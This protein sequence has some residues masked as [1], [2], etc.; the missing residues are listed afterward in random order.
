MR[1]VRIGKRVIGEGQ[2]CF[3]IAEAGVN[4]NGDLRLVKRLVKAAAMA[5]ADAVKFQTFSADS[6][7]T[8]SARK[9]AYQKRTSDASESQYEMLKRLELPGMAFSVLYEYAD[10]CGIEFL[11][12][13]FD[14]DSAELLQS[15]GV[16]AFKIPSGEITNIPLLE[17]M[18]GYKKPV[19]LSTGMAE[20][21]EIREGIAGVLRGGAKQI[22]LL[23]CITRY[24]APIE[25]ANLLMIQTLAKEFDLPVGFSD[26]TEGTFA[27]TIARALGACVI[28]KHFTLDR[29]LPGPDHKA[30]LEPGELT[31]LVRQI[32]A[33]ES[34]LGDGRKHIDRTEAA[35]RNIARKSLI[36]ATTIRKGARISSDMIGIKRP[37]T[38]IEPGRLDEVVGKLAGRTIRKDSVLRWDMLQ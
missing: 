5:G 26:H 7:A 13:P 22:V 32:R 11:S 34:A 35:I 33:V 30:S 20:M 9:A 10:S 8:R 2:P 28:E 27:A 4:H 15:I 18:G 29:S 31:D 23:H 12:S 16:R 25:S 21:D 3:I 14:T 19:I 38:G 1:N 6:I 17:K 36:A 37:G 24:P